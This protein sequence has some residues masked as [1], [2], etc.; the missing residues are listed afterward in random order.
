M[1][2]MRMEY[3]IFDLILSE[4]CSSALIGPSRVQELP[5]SAK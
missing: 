2:P 3:S 1:S 5:I 4:A